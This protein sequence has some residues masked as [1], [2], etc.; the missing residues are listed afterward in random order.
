MCFEYEYIISARFFRLLAYATLAQGFSVGWV[1]MKYPGPQP[2]LRCD[3]VGTPSPG[4]FSFGFG[5]GQ[6][7]VPGGTGQ[8]WR[9]WWTVSLHNNTESQVWGFNSANPSVVGVRSIIERDYV[10]FYFAGIGCFHSIQ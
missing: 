3:L 2:Q 1:T 9:D 10:L 8:L 4:G 7:L 6:S 5:Q